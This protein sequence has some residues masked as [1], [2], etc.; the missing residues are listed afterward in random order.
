[1]QP[2]TFP[3]QGGNLIPHHT[4][5]DASLAISEVL[6]PKL[7]LKQLHC[8]RHKKLFSSTESS[9]GVGD[10][11]PLDASLLDSKTCRFVQE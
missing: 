2:V 7:V 8:L 6:F 9:V 10:A 4:N 3:S 11:S 5:R 1:M